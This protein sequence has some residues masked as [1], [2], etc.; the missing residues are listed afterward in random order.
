MNAKQVSGIRDKSLRI[1]IHVIHVILVTMERRGISLLQIVIMG[2]AGLTGAL[3]GGFVVYL[4]VNSSL[5]AR[6]TLISREVVSTQMPVPVFTPEPILVPSPPSINTSQQREVEVHTVEISTA[7]TDVVEL[8]SLLPT[9][10][11][12]ALNQFTSSGSAR[13]RARVYSSDLS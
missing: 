8:I 3:V 1:Y 11:V 5:E 6:S 4:A 9:K 13:F 2:L 12:S 7:I 10:W